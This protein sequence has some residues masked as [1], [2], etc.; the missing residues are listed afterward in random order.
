MSVC[1]CISWYMCVY[2][3]IGEDM[4]S[5]TITVVGNGI[6]NPKQFVFPF[7]LQMPLGKTWIPLLSSQLWVNSKVD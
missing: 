5:I 6:S 1:L 7:F 2:T 3:Y 4:L